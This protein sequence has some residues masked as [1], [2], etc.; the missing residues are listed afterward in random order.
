MI[1][2]EVTVGALQPRT[3]YVWCDA[4]ISAS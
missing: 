3:Y 1:Q 2:F 4:V